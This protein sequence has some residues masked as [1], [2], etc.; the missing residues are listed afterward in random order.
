MCAGDTTL[1]AKATVLAYGSEARVGGTTCVSREAGITC[2]N[3]AG[4]GFTISVGRY[5]LL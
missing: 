1:N 3:G 5:R 2:T 4:H